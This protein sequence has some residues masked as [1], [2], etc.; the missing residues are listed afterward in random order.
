MSPP[1]TRQ[2]G[3]G[4]VI[5]C[6]WCAL[7]A[8][9][10]WSNR[11][12]GLVDDNREVNPAWPIKV[13]PMTPICGPC[14]RLVDAGQLVE[15]V[16]RVLE[17]WTRAMGGAPGS[18]PYE[19]RRA[20]VATLQAGVAAWYSRRDACGEIPWEVELDCA[21]CGRD[22]WHTDP[23]DTEERPRCTECGTEWVAPV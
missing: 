15:F 22:T 1:E 10:V 13:E 21:T 20:A 8:L 18:Q 7:P 16:N 3:G 4:P 12:P 9:Y 14:A 23:S 17:E 6:E 11:D 19:W 5:E 2:A